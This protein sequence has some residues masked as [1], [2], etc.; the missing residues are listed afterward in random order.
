MDNYTDEGEISRAV[1]TEQYRNIL[2]RYLDEATVIHDNLRASELRC[3]Y[4]ENL[5]N[6][7]I[8]KLVSI[9]AHLLPKIEGGGEQ[10][11]NLLDEF[12]KFRPWLYDSIRP[13]TVYDPFKNRNMVSELFYLVIRAYHIL[14][15]SN[16]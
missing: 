8:S 6:A 3:K 2:V 16:Y 15:L 5:I 9:M 10:T 12:E 11:K 4:D 13:K 14:G 1:E 7:A